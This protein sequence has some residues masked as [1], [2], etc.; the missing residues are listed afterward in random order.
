MASS[1][2]SSAANSTATFGGAA[3]LSEAG[4]ATSV[5]SMLV[6]EPASERVAAPPNVAVEFAAEDAPEDAMAVE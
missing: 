4:S 1:G 6:A 2:A 3:T 5:I